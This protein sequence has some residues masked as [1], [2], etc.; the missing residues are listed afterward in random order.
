[1]IEND[2]RDRGLAP[3]GNPLPTDDSR[4]KVAPPPGATVRQAVRSRQFMLLYAACVIASFGVFVPF[5]HLVPYAMD[6]GIAA[7]SA[8]LLFG[9]IGIGS[10]AGRFFLGGLADKIG[11]QVAHLMMFI[12]MAAALLIW[13]GSSTFWALAAFAFAYGVF[14]G[15]WVAVLP[16]IVMDYFGGRSVSGIIGAL[17]TS[18][19]L[20]TLIGPSAAGFVFD[21]SGSYT[22]PILASVCANLVA[23]G[24]VGSMLKTPTLAAKI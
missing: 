18:V 11:R 5:V 8:A 16:A 9:M 21:A 6:H 23:A 12:G 3:D 20:G 22:L 4:A 2:P 1:L 14:Y 10:T 15:G 13:A 7:T 24:I 19:A 17:Y